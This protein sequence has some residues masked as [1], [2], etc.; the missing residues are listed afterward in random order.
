MRLCISTITSSNATPPPVTSP[1]TL[2][3]S[4]T[5]L[6]R[7]SAKSFCQPTA[8]ALLA[9]VRSTTLRWN[10]P[11]A[12]LAYR[13]RFSR[14]TRS[15]RGTT[16][17]MSAQL[18]S[19]NTQRLRCVAIVRSFHFSPTSLP[20][21][22]ITALARPLGTLSILPPRS[23]RGCETDADV[24]SN[25]RVFDRAFSSASFLHFLRM[26]FCWPPHPARFG[27]SLSAACW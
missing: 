2:W 25:V 18:A 11:S 16:D 14:S 24:L 20:A 15:L 6:R 1:S 9:T 27:R 5:A 26:Q 8:A 19:Q 12:G 17:F 23:Y 10:S 21:S 4:F 13:R 7:T 22:P 3:V